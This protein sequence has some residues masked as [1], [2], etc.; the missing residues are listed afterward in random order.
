MKLNAL[1]EAIHKKENKN[2]Y[3]REKEVAEEIEESVTCQIL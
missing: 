3:S 1:I 2:I